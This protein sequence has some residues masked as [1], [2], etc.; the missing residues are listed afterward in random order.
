MRQETRI[1]ERRCLRIFL[2]LSIGVAV[3]TLLYTENQAYKLIWLLPFGY[4]VSTALFYRI[5]NRIRYNYGVVFVVS[6]V[7]IFI[8]YVVTPFSMVCLNVYNGMGFGPNPSHSSIVY[9]II[10]M[11]MELVAV[12]LFSCFAVARCRR[13]QVGL[14]TD[15][16]K[17]PILLKNKG[18]VLIFTFFMVPIIMVLRPDSLVPKGISFIGQTV[19]HGTELFLPGLVAMIIPVVRMNL[20]FLG[21]ALLK[22]KYSKKN[23]FVHMV[24][25]WLLVLVYLSTLISTSRWT[26]VFSAIMCIV[27]MRTLFPDIPKAFYIVL[28]IVVFVTFT[29][30]SIYKFSWALQ[31]SSNPYVDVFRILFAQFQEYFS[32]PRVVAQGMDMVDAFRNQYDISTLVNDFLGSIPLLSRYVDQANRTNVFF[33]L[34]LGVGNVTQIIPMLI[35]GYAYFPYFPM[36]FTVIAQWLMITF[37]FKSQAAKRLEFTY[38]YGYVGLLFAISMGFNVQI[39]FGNFIVHFVTPWIFWNL[40]SKVKFHS[41]A[42]KTKGGLLDGIS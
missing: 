7:V 10:L 41:S 21:L 28:S 16:K 38:I 23:S 9:A 6:N 5:F 3:Y 4:F 12:Y 19:N 31:L 22:S 29:S 35:N 37:D 20:L 26:I 8:R 33:N 30:I 27:V 15:S 11:L 13:R 18:M 32:G 14:K 25:A 1:W 2:S 24:I 39:I 36:I 42:Y 34:Y 40:N 17:A